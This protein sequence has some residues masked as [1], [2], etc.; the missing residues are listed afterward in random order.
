[1]YII[2]PEIA[3]VPFASKQHFSFWPV[4]G[5]WQN[6]IPLWQQL[7]WG[8]DRPLT[9]T[10]SHRAGREG[11]ELQHSRVSVSICG[12]Y[13]FVHLHYLLWDDSLWLCWI[14]LAIP[15]NSCASSTPAVSPHCLYVFTVWWKLSSIWWC[16]PAPGN[17]GNHCTPWGRCRFS[18]LGDEDLL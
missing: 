1:M 12:F 4:Q 2:K 9:D 8:R 14:C 3:F 13:H 5:P 15:S 16:L 11:P 6:R 17:G 7:R 18:V 10:N